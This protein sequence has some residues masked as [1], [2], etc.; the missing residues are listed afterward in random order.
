MYYSEVD[1]V[2]AQRLPMPGY[3]AATDAA[4]GAGTSAAVANGFHNLASPY[5]ADVPSNI[6]SSRSS[7]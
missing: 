2:Y 6:S 7:G 1:R 5:N 4:L 3:A